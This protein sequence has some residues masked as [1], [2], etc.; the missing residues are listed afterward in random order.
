MNI[1]YV[2]V[3]FVLCCNCTLDVSINSD[4]RVIINQPDANIV[5]TLDR[6]VVCSSSMHARKTIDT[7]VGCTTDGFVQ[8][9]IKNQFAIH[10]HPERVID[11]HYYAQIIVKS[12][13]KKT[14][15]TTKEMCVLNVPIE[16][17][18]DNSAMFAAST[19]LCLAICGVLAYIVNVRRTRTKNDDVFKLTNDSIAAQLDLYK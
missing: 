8:F 16:K 3:F 19:L 14:M 9:S 12:F 10:P 17:K 1:F 15:E 2:F 5:S 6:L 18:R 11:D 13:N 7:S 4:H